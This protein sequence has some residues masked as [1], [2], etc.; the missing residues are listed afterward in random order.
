MSEDIYDGTD[1]HFGGT[2]EL[3]SAYISNSNNRI[4][5]EELQALIRETF[6]TL[7]SLNSGSSVPVEEAEDYSKS[8]AEIKKSIGAESLTSFIDGKPYKS[9]KRHLTTN[10]YSPETY[11]ATFGLPADY[12][13]THPTYSAKRSELAKALGLGQKGRQAKNPTAKKPKAAKA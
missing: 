2:I 12:P 7:S 1:D 5:P 9:L 11:K 6:A 13:L 8:K 10:G 3:V 4:A